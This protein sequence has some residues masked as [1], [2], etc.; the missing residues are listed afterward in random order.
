MKHDSFKSKALTV[1][2]SALPPVEQIPIDNLLSKLYEHVLNGV[3]CSRIIFK[4]D[5]PVDRL[6]L[7]TNPAYR[8]QTGM[9]DV[10]GRLGSEVHHG[11]AAEERD[12]LLKLARVAKTGE[13][14]VFEHFEPSTGHW[15]TMSAYSP[16]RGI[17]VKVFDNI[18][19]RKRMEKE[20]E[21][22]REKLEARVADQVQELRESEERYRGLFE[23]LP[24]GIIMQAPNGEITEANQAACDILRLSMD[25]FTGMTGLDPSWKPIHE[26][27]SPFPGDEHPAMRALTTGEP[28]LGVIMGLGE[29]DSQTW[30]SINSHPLF[31]KGREQPY[32][33]LSSFMDIT[34]RVRSEESI[35]LLKSRYEDFLAASTEFAIMATDLDGTITMFNRGAELLLGYTE[36]EVVGRL[37]PKAFHPPEQMESAR[38]EI[39]KR[40]GTSLDGLQ[41]VL[42]TVRKDGRFSRDWT[43]LRKDGTK[44]QAEVCI[45]PVRNTRGELTGHLA[46]LQNLAGRARLDEAFQQ[47]ARI[48][49]TKG[50]STSEHSPRKA[51]SSSQAGKVS[52]RRRG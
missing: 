16:E 52:R 38:I 28:Q 11:V 27:S 32:A 43:Y 40:L 34:K 10:T 51:K 26:D 19:A 21:T 48:P 6:Y 22:Y 8:S 1:S 39:S 5:Q 14:E 45:T 47:S 3:C 46:V 2:G 37:T 49:Q 30:V 25:Q 31:R 7:Y 17:V 15:F 20:R 9:Q 50:H 12:L 42:A 4:G 36:K 18:T 24:V 33:A 44:V 13:S 41:S 35:R 23:S 29:G